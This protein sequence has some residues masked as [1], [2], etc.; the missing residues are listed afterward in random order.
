M[1]P[2]LSSPRSQP[3][4]E[5]RLPAPPPHWRLPGVPACADGPRLGVTRR[6]W[7]GCGAGPGTGRGSYF[8]RS[9]LGPNRELGPRAGRGWACAGAAPPVSGYVMRKRAFDVSG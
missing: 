5:P 8:I 9:S 1:E 2:P 6:G 7:E 3:G 4:V